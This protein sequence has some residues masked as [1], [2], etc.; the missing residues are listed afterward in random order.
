MSSR[1][2]IEASMPAFVALLRRF[3]IAVV[4][5]DHANYPAIADVTGDFVYARLQKGK[6]TIPTGYPPKELDAWAE[7]AANLGAGGEP[8]DLPRV[9]GK[10]A[11]K[12][13]RATY[14]STS[15]TK[16]KCA[17]RPPRWR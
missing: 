7:R 15:S 8:G 6:D 5:A 9:D 1:C 12:Q 14:S 17:R 11:A 4:Y 16:A 2:G 3:D 13:S 10:T